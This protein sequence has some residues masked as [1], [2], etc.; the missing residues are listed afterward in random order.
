MPLSSNVEDIIQLMV[1]MS[2]QV[3]NTIMSDLIFIKMPTRLT[4]HLRTCV[5]MCV[6]HAQLFS[7]HLRMQYS[8]LT[9][10]PFLLC[11]KN[12][13]VLILDNLH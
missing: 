8:M 6:D 11:N 3:C 9:Y 1:V 2:K 5:R 13:P 4:G 7:F 12:V 10:T